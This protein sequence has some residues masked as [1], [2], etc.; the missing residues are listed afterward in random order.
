MSAHYI[1]RMSGQQ[2]QPTHWVRGVSSTA[3]SELA[4]AYDDDDVRTERPEAPGWTPASLF[5]GILFFLD[6]EGA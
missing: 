3:L 2:A 5:E 4:R 6:A 1:E